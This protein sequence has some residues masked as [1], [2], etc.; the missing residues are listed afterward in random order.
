[1]RLF[2]LLLSF[3]ISTCNANIAHVRIG[4]DLCEKEKQ[5]LID[6]QTVVKNNLEQ[7]LGKKIPYDKVPTIAVVTSGGGYRAL[8]ASLGFL[9]GAEKMDFLDCIT[10]ISSLSG[11]A[12]AVSTWMSSGK[13]V[14][15]FRETLIP[16]LKKG[17]ALKK[18]RELWLLKDAFWHHKKRYPTSL[19][20]VYGFVLGNALLRDYGRTRHTLVLSTQE[21]QLVSGAKPFPIYSAVSAFDHHKDWFAFT[22]FEFGSCVYGMHIPMWA[23]GRKFAYGVSIN[24]A[25][26][27]NLSSCLGIW[28]SAFTATFDRMYEGA[29]DFITSKVVKKVIEKLLKKIG[30]KRLA[31]ARV[32]NFAR[33]MH[34]QNNPYK[35]KKHIRLADAGVDFNLAYPPVSGVHEGRKPD[36]IIFV[37]ASR[38]LENAPH[39][40]KVEQWAREHNQPFPKIDY[41]D[42][43]KKAMSVFIDKD[44][45]DA[46]VVV[47]M[48]WIKDEQLFESIQK[49]PA[50]STYIPYLKDF[51]PYWALHHSFADTRNFKYNDQQAR[52]VSYLMESNLL[53]SKKTLADTINWVIENRT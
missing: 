7:F 12:W 31:Y 1:M 35:H 38:R 5:Y 41:A 13:P 17:F 28:G 26:E 53:A 33:A 15:E 47:Y 16:H 51:D 20:D 27:K 21:N 8:L 10:Y 46:P 43:N 18:F 3:F 22:P 4:F 39:F 32:P 23:F 6:R 14:Q 24:N 36:I 11:S 29:H 52:Q 37:D 25:P 19:V 44:N 45:K 2:F 42:I 9:A 50:F 34:N 49:D 30:H 48:P 40:Q